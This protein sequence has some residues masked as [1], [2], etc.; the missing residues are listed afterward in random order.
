MEHKM[1]DAASVS[2]TMGSTMVSDDATE[3]SSTWRSIYEKNWPWVYRLVRRL[4]GQDV[5]AEDVT[6]D[7]FVAVYRK[8]PEFEGR[9]KLET[10]IYRICCNI[11]SEH[12]RRAWR[13]RRLSAALHVSNLWRPHRPAERQVMA[14]RELEIARD[15]LS[16]LDERKRQVFVLRELEELSGA[17]VAEILDIP[18]A[19]VRTRLFHARKE[20]LELLSKAGL[21]VQS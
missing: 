16:R 12:R 21:E 2:L 4:G 5:D 18:E 13:R 6:Q 19:T 10:W 1:A 8:L 9:S 20:F 17:E 14:R 11:V 7:V 15:L 3:H